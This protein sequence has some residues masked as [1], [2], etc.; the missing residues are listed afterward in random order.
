MT[1]SGQKCRFCGEGKLVEEVYSK[2]IKMGRSNF[3]VE[4]LHQ[5]KCNVCDSVVTNAQQYER[6]SDLIEAAEQGTSAFV[7]IGM[8]REFR[9]KYD[10]S[11]KEASILIG[12]GEG[13]FGKYE[14]GGKLSRPTAKLIRVALKIPEVVEFLAREEN[15]ELH[16]DAILKTE[17]AW[18]L[19][20]IAM[21]AVPNLNWVE[22]TRRA[23]AHAKPHIVT[24]SSNDE[25]FEL[26]RA[27]LREDSWRLAA[28]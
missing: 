17:N 22:E 25:I 13:A 2:T 10:L 24:T 18:E 16:C 15:I 4:G 9:E 11:Q 7:S 26:D 3:L 19:Q 8:L 28:V 20:V 5:F 21:D 14:S 12:A 23:I 27:I 1:H 6:N